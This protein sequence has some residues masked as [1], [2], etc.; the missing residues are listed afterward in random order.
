LELWNLF[1]TV[2]AKIWTAQTDKS[3]A[4]PIHGAIKIVVFA[5]DVFKIRRLPRP[6]KSGLAMTEYLE[7]DAYIKRHC[8]DC[9]NQLNPTYL[10]LIG[11]NRP[12]KEKHF[13]HQISGNRFVSKFK[14]IIIP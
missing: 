12:F 9:H 3:E 14:F 8:E 7:D 10:L 4:I 13:S 11:E 5:N 1:L 6:D 2:I